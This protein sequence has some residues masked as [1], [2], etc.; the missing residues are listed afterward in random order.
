MV[1][2]DETRLRLEM[3]LE[4]GEGYLSATYALANDG[5]VPL[6]VFDRLF[7]TDPRGART[8]DPD[9]CWR[10]VDPDGQYVMAKLIPAVPRGMRVESPE[11]PY[12]RALPAGE[13]LRGRAVVPLPLDQRLPYGQPAPVPAAA[14]VAGVSLRLGYA[15]PDAEYSHTEIP[16]PDGPVLSVLPPWA[17]KRHRVLRSAPLPAR[18]PLA[19]N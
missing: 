3:A 7:A 8:V 19:R 13:M 4:P 2:F 18:L 12:A 17:R 11:L 10:W 1:P 15:V 14:E 16:T 5:P 9:L 6:V